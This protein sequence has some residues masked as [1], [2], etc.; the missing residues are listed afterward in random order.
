[1]V[2]SVTFR[3]GN[4]VTFMVALAACVIAQAQLPG[5]AQAVPSQSVLDAESE[6]LVEVR[7]IANDAR[8][9]QVLVTNQGAQPLTLRLPSAFAGVPVLA[10]M[11]GQQGAGFGA[12]GIGGT[13]QNV[14]GGGAQNAGMGIGGGAGGGGNP[15]CWVAREVYGVHDPRWLEFRNWMAWQAPDVLRDVYADHGEAFSVWL[16]ER[17]V[18][19]AVVRLAMDQVVSSPSSRPPAGLLRVNPVIDSA[20]VPF[21]V[22]AG[23]TVAVRAPTVC[24]DYGRREP[25]PRIPYRLVAIETVSQDPRLAVILGGLATG[26]VPQ[27]VAQAA[28][29]HLSSGRTWDQLAAEVIKR[30]GG[31]PDVPFFS[32][33]DLAAAQRAVAIATKIVGDRPSASESGSASSEH[34]N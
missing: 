10:Q 34:Q 31:D 6:G 8:S 28:A 4:A 32:A 13:P 7:F 33:A 1:M 9:A 27:K 11:G 14:G 30:A 26:H 17:P 19:K 3:L 24:L 16:Q 20:S 22:P 29:W 18:A 23:K 2:R 12:G 25:T 15:F 21:T 5:H